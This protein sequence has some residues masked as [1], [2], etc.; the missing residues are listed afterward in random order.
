MEWSFNIIKPSEEWRHAY[1]IKL[2]FKAL[3]GDNACLLMGIETY[4]AGGNDMSRSEQINTENGIGL[5][6]V[7]TTKF[8]GW[9]ISWINK[10]FRQINIENNI[11][12]NMGDIWKAIDEQ[13]SSVIQ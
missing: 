12:F 2:M 10:Y 6:N 9:N 3:P 13:D 5:F 4:Q 8:I 11:G 7:T 1:R